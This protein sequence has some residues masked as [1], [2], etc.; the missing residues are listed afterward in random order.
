MKGSSIMSYSEIYLAHLDATKYMMELKKAFV[1]IQLGFSHTDSPQAAAARKLIQK[2]D[3]GLAINK[4]QR[5]RVEKAQFHVM[6]RFCPN[7]FSNRDIFAV[8]YDMQQVDGVNVMKASC[9]CG[10]CDIVWF[11]EVLAE[12]IPKVAIFNMPPAHWDLS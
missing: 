12:R 5:V 2:L 10:M 3:K 4:A 7:C 9:S 1:K 6:K 8:L 11:E